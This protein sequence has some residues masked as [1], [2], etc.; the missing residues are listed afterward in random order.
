[1]VA[2]HQNAN[3]RRK[4]YLHRKYLAD[5]AELVQQ[6]GGKCA[7]CG[8]VHNLE[9][10]HLEPRTWITR[11]VNRPQR[12]VLYRREAAEGKLNLL[13]G[14]CNKKHGKP[15]RQRKVTTHDS[16]KTSRRSH[17]VRTHGDPDCVSDR[18]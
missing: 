7:H 8:T 6:L 11:K 17:R 3:Q 5:R 16:P 1:M 15:G 4:E 12:M 13:C 9:F 2:P 10:N 18:S 14:T